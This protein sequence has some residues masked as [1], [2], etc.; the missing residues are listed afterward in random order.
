MPSTIE[1]V[2]NYTR[3]THLSFD[4]LLDE[5]DNNLQAAWKR[6]IEHHQAAS[7]REVLGAAARTTCRSTWGLHH[8]ERLAGSRD[9]NNHGY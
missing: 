4:D 6:S 8:I 3:S 7:V 1:R 9:L 2:S 5:Q